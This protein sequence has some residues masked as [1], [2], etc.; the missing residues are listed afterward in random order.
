MSEYKDIP[1]LEGEYAIDTKGNLFSHYR[2]R[3]KKPQQ[4]PQGYLFYGLSQKRQ[5]LAH[6]LVAITYIPNPDNKEFVNHKNGVKTDNRVENLEWCTRQEN[7]DHAFS[8]GLKNSTGSNN[9]MSV[10]DEGKVRTIK[11]L[12]SNNIKGLYIAKQLGVS[13][14]NISRIKNGL[15]WRHVA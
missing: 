3:E 7:E 14:A 6:R 4:H 15:I 10:L 9:V 2:R 1:G 11:E 12:L 13:A 8:T 5:A